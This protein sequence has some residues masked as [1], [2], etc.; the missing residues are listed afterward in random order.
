MYRRCRGQSHEDN[1]CLLMVENLW[2]RFSQKLLIDSIEHS[3]VPITQN[4][5][6]ISSTTQEFS[7]EIFIEI[8][9]AR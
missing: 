2:M 6:S 3:Q 1:Q 7:V 5:R 9:G 4:F 8:S